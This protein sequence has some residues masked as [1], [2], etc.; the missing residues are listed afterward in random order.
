MFV[1]WPPGSDHLGGHQAF[2][3]AGPQVANTGVGSTA[4]G[5]R[6]IAY[7]LLA[8]DIYQWAKRKA[9]GHMLQAFRYS[10]FSDAEN[11]YVIPSLY[12]RHA[13]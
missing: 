12:V 8:V 3:A 10:R 2:V 13:V 7:L 11:R 6:A 4:L 1:D 5:P 9:V